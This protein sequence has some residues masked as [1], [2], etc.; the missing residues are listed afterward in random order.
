[1]AD[2]NP[3]PPLTA[4]QWLI[5]AMAAIGFAFDIYEILV[6]PLILEDAVNALTGFKFG[7][8]G[9]KNWSSA[10]LFAPLVLG[11][12]FGL[13]GGYLTD[14][15]GRRRVLVW[16]IMLYAISAVAAGFATNPWMFLFFRC[17]TLIG[18]CVEFVAAVAWLAEIFPNRRQREKVLGFTQAFSSVGGLLSAGAL[19]LIAYLAK[20]QSLPAIYGQHEVWRYMLISGVL[21]AIPLILIRPFMPE[22]PVWQQKK[23]A[24]TLKR[25]SFA[26]LFQP[27]LRRTTIVATLLFACAYG[28]A[29][30]AIQFL[31]QIVPR[32]PD[33]VKA[34]SARPEVQEASK[35]Q[36]GNVRRTL[37]KPYVGVV[38]SWQE[39]GGLLGRFALAGVVLVVLSRQWQL[40]VFQIPGLFLAPLVFWYPATDNYELLKWG[41]AFA[42]FCTVAQFSFWGNYLP[43]AYPTHLRGTGG[44]FAANI[45]GRILGT[46]M[47][48]LTTYLSAY[49]PGPEGSNV[50]LAHAAAVVI[51][52]VFLLG[53]I[54]SFFL[55]EPPRERAEE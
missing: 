30:G 51:G 29:F 2:E 40:R 18:V 45:G 20:N 19:G 25:P 10:F 53:L 5:C 37:S 21:P 6:M 35:E 31:P 32:N 11:G 44:I 15:L 47:F 7:E 26:E 50:P 54:L 48:P 28:A 52:S 27:A 4:S 41:A 49:M 17:T 23:D 16:S 43:A 39:I 38:Q 24:G 12:V 55:P 36:A 34:V 42:G 1:M 14:L 46:A 3:A 9:Y 22:S 8:D 13:I 33:V